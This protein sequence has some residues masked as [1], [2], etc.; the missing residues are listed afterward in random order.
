MQVTA[1]ASITS[2]YSH[3]ST[4][5]LSRGSRDA[6]VSSVPSNPNSRDFHPQS[7]WTN[8]FFHRKS[9][10]LRQLAAAFCRRFLPK[11]GDRPVEQL[12]RA[13]RSGNQ[14]VLDGRIDGVILTE[15]DLRHLNV[16]RGSLR[17]LREDSA[18]HLK[19]CA[20]PVWEAGPSRFDAMHSF[21]RAHTRTEASNSKRSANSSTDNRC[22]TLAT[23]SW[24]Q[25]LYHFPRQPTE[26]WFAG[27]FFYLSTTHEFF[28]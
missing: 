28:S 23:M 25:S 19:V 1:P 7:K 21:C 17:G 27:F 10:V 4:A 2:D 12:V 22:P 14:N 5:R 8:L 15:T 24:M 9:D 13:A 26:R 16:S 6:S 18:D 20:L 11:F 3:A